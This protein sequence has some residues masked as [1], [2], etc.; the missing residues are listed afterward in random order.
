MPRPNSDRCVPC[1]KWSHRTVDA[2]LSAALAASRKYDGTPYRTYKC[3]R[4]NGW[5]LT[6]QPLRPTTEEVT[7]P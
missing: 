2:G 5:H 7:N 3:P 6:R 1:G 4:G